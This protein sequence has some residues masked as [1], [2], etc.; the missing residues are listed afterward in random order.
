MWAQA[1]IA[2]WTGTLRKDGI[3]RVRDGAVLLESDAKHYSAPVKSDGTFSFRNLQPGGYSLTVSSGGHL[4]HSITR[5]LV[6]STASDVTLLLGRDGSVEIAG[7]ETGK[8]T[9]TDQ[10]TNKGVNEIPLN[11]RDFSQI[12][13]LAAGTASDSNGASNFTQQFAINGQRGVEATFGM[14]GADITDPAMGGGTFTNFNVDAISELHSSAGVMPAEIG[15]GASGY[16]NILTRSGLNSLHGSF[17][18]FL[19]NSALDARNYFDHPSPVSPGRIPPFRRNEFGFT[20]G[21]PLLPTRWL[22]ADRPIFYFIEYQ[23]FRQVL[24]TTQILSV[25]TTNQKL[26][27]DTTAFQGDTL[28]VPVNTSI[29]AILARYPSPNYP[30][31]TFGVN[32]YATS[33]KVVTNADQFSGRL[34]FQLDPKNRVMGRFSLDNLTGPTTNP[35]Q[36]VIAPSFVWNTSTISAMAS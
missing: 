33:S 22:G 11:K 19:R 7:L 24:G 26:G 2:N 1:P 25:P 23:G 28:F 27:T 12:L 35:D 32:T 6:S 29:G 3:S 15:N 4:Y 34:D 21:G 20:N 8:T 5:V 9:D 36:T 30:V 10:L 18:E 13:L 14:D 16:T 17:F 31:G